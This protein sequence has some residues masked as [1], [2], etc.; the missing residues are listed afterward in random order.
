MGVSIGGL[1]SL[2]SSSGRI[3][4]LLTAS[5]KAFDSI[6]V[7]SSIDLIFILNGGIAWYPVSKDVIK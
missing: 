5:S 2:I 7:E 4:I 3:S 6:K 1:I